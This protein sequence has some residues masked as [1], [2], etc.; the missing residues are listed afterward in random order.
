MIAD[1]VAVKGNPLEA[2]ETVGNIEAVVHRG[3]LFKQAGLLKSLQSFFAAE[4][5]DTITQDL[6]DVTWN[7]QV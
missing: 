3:V 2:I 4:P 5:K 7:A 6:L 1:M